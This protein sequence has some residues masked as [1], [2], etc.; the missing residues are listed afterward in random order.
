[1][2]SESSWIEKNRVFFDLSE[3]QLL[4]L[5][6]YGEARGE[7]WE[8]RIGVLNVVRNRVLEAPKYSDKVILSRN[9]SK[10]HSVILKEWQFSCF[11]FGN[12]NR[13]LLASIARDFIGTLKVGTI[14]RDIYIVCRVKDFIVDNTNGANHYYA[15]YIS[16]PRWVREMEETCRI[17][18]HIFYKG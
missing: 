12:P 13:K 15:Y 2:V 8:G 11:N 10:Y 14:L 1:M 9:F 5:L 16:P 7:S 18:G 17:G 4:T 6:I 3:D